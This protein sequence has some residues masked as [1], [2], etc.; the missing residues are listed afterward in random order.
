MSASQPWFPLQRQLSR[1]YKCKSKQTTLEIFRC[2][3][4]V[5]NDDHFIEVRKWAVIQ[6]IQRETSA[7]FKRHFTMWPRETAV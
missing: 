4:T 2:H 6:K 7:R 1:K 5:C 3:G